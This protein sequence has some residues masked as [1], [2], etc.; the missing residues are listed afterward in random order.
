MARLNVRWA[1][2]ILA[3]LALTACGG[4]RDFGDP[5]DCADTGRPVTVTDR[6]GDA[7]SGRGD[8]VEAAL[9]RGGGR[10][11]ATF[12]LRDEVKAP[13]AVALVLTPDG[14]PPSQLEVLLL[15]GTDPR[16]RLRTAEGVR[17]VRAEVGGKGNRLSVRTALPAQGAFR[18]QA[19]AIAAGERRDVAPEAAAP[20]P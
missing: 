6:E 9:A 13:T 12:E 17:D 19:Q 4:A 1:V 10:L 16:V 3:S 18:W 2:G 7:R 20:A 14:A 15:G 11:C 8:L 5:V